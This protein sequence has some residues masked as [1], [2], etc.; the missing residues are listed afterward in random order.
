MRCSTFSWGVAS[1][2]C[3]GR[4]EANAAVI[5]GMNEKPMPTPRTSS[6]SEMPAIE[7]PAPMNASGIVLRHRIET[8]T[9][10]TRPPPKRSVRRPATGITISMPRPCGPTSRPVAI[11]LSW[12]TSW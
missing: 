12:R 9:S 8:P 7:V 3:S 2:S 1:E 10:A 5:A 4:S 11:R 6:T